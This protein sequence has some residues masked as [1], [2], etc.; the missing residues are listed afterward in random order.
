MVLVDLAVKTF[1]VVAL[2]ILLLTVYLY[3]T[4]RS[5]LYFPWPEPISAAPPGVEAI[6]LETD[7]GLRLGA[8]FVPAISGSTE[9]GS[10]L[11]VCNGNARSRG[12]RDSLGQA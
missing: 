4:Q 9:P 5:Q 12:H 2:A 1:V 3:V 10:A 8:W 7:D 11:L 6:E